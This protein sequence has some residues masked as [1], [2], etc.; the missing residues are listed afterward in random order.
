MR[1][2]AQEAIRKNFS[3][4]AIANSLNNLLQDAS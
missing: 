3:I 2:M 1:K 4:L